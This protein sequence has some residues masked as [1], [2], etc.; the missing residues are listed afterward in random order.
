LILATGAA[1]VRPSIPG[2][3]LPGVFTLRNLRDTDQIKERVDRGVK[4]AVL[5]GG[6]F[7]SLEL[8]ENFV[9]RGISTTVV[10]KND[11]VLTP[12]DKEMITPIVQELVDKGVT[13]LLGQSAE[14]LEESANGLV[15]CLKS[16]Q[17]L[18]ANLVIVGVGVRPENKLAVDAGL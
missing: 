6:G 4:Q 2:M 5:L 1:P 16:G 10:E 15:V 11:Q 14:A 13:L 18:P 3:D 12:F 9:R 7:I 17:R 8:A